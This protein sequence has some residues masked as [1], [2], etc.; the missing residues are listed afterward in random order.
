MQIFRYFLSIF[1]RISNFNAFQLRLFPK[2][3]HPFFNNII[4]ISDVESV[5]I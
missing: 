5:K 2:I 3:S 4:S 1:M